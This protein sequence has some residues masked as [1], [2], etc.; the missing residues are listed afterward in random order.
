MRSAHEHRSGQE[1]SA[2]R[3]GFRRRGHRQAHA[4]GRAAAHVAPDVVAA[5]RVSDPVRR[6]ACRAG[7]ARRR[8]DPVGAARRRMS[9]LRAIRI[10]L[11]IFIV[12]LVV[13]GLTAFPLESELRLAA[14]I[15]H[16]GPFAD[17]MP[18]LTE[19]IDR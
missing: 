9:P 5:L 18:H 15:L 4:E 12:G 11:A 3:E 6:T 14:S 8:R 10:W 2:E 19:W 7:G 13:S 16:A 1:E 17:W